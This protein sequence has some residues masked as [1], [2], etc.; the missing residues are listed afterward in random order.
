MSF[1]FL[2]AKSLPVEKWRY[3]SKLEGLSHDRRGPPPDLIGKA[4]HKGVNRVEVACNGGGA[5]G[6]VRRSEEALEAVAR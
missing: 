1:A 3:L 5:R 2:Q 4:I 6:S